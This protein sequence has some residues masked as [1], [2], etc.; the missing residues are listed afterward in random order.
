VRVKVHEDGW[1]LGA[2]FSKML[3]SREQ[4]RPVWA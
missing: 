3:A 2:D 1:M 4:A